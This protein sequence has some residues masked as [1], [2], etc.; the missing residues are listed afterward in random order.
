M[1]GKTGNL[2]RRSDA[3]RSNNAL[4]Q[5]SPYRAIITPRAAHTDDL[6]TRLRPIM[7]L[8]AAALAVFGLGAGAISL[9]L[10]SVDQAIAFAWPGIGAGLTLALLAPEG[11]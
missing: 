9:M 4:D 1:R 2:E 8:S 6:M 5:I 7:I 10:G 11:R 3:V